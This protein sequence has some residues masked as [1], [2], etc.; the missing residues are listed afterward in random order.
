MRPV[1]RPSQF[2]NE[3]PEELIS[4]NVTK[5]SRTE[6]KASPKKSLGAKVEKWQVGDRLYHN[7]FGEGV[8]THVLGLGKKSTIAIQFTTGRKILDPTHTAIE[9]I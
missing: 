5:R 8:V 9:K 1:S 7:T 6:F 3:L 4:T 2:L